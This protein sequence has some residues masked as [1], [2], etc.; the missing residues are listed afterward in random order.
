[1]SRKTKVE[2]QELQPIQAD[3]PAINRWWIY[4]K[5]RFPIF[6]HGPLIAAFS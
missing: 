5:E 1:M 2:S 4:Q 6:G 3:A